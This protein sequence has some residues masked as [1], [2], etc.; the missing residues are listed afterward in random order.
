MRKVILWNRAEY[1]I[2]NEK[3]ELLINAIE[4]SKAEGTG[5]YLNHAGGRVWIGSAKAI[6]LIA[7][8]GPDAPVPIEYSK[9]LGVTHLSDEQR[10]ANLVRFSQMRK[11]F[12]ED[13]AKKLA[14]QDKIKREKWATDKIKEDKARKKVM[15]DAEKWR[16]KNEN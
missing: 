15:E 14:E 3:E 6:A 10:V 5:F 7:D 16:K 12:A 9:R 8:G 13:R 4:L 2:P 1:F 11:K